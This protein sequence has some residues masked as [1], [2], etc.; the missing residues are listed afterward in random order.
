MDT[1]SIV[2]DEQATP[3]P[4]ESRPAKT[5][6]TKVTYHG[7]AGQVFR[8]HIMN[9]LMNIITLGIYSFWGKT[10][11]R[12]YMTSH[13]AILNDR[14]E[15]TGTGKELFFGWLKAMLIFMPILV[16]MSIPV[17]NII[18]FIIFFGIL[19]LAM[20]LALRYRLSRTKWRGIRFNL[21]GSLKEYFFLSIKRSLI[22]F[23]TLGWKIPKSDILIWSY[24]A[25]NM[26]YGDLKF[27]YEGDHKRLQKIHLITLSIFIAAF[28]VGL[29]PLVGG[30]IMK[31]QEMVEKAR[32]KSQSAQTTTQPMADQPIPYSESYS[33]ALPTSSAPATTEGQIQQV[34]PQ[35]GY[36]ETEYA[37]DVAA[38]PRSKP[39]I[40]SKMITGVLFFYVGFGAAFIVRM[41]YHAALWQ[42]KFRG[43]RLGGIRFKADISGGG[44]AKL[45][46]TNM[47]IILFTL[48]LGKPIAAHRTLR[49]YA[50][51]MRIGGDLQELLAKQDAT[52]QRSGMGDALAADV[53]F[54][55]GM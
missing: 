36:E 8:L 30:G 37:E 13:M 51:N 27:S 34:S 11:I 24:I 49:Y 2:P 52:R 4:A 18:G 25:N 17:V 23:F 15:Y 46:V 42:E 6:V 21:G 19:S 20:Y 45:F 40:D 48:G 10:R 39:E 3:K 22:N 33:D 29:A 41:W 47:L 14:F 55:L 50:S 9:L 53:G 54:D 7:K 35:A 43:L 5:P 44:L 1:L 38:P 16:L 31:G 32:V 26:S 28:V 12:R